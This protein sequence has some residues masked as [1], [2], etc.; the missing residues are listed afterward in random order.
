MTT[1]PPGPSRQ[2][3]VMRR[4][5]AA[6]LAA[7]QALYQADIGQVAPDT[8]ALEF[9]QHR[10]SEDFDGFTLGDIDQQLFIE[11]FRGAHAVR[12]D[13]DDMLM[14][15]IAEGWSV[16]RLDSMLRHILR[17]AAWELAYRPQVHAKV[18]VSE[19]VG[20][21]HDFFDEREAGM[22]NG[23]LNRLARELR[24]D[25]FQAD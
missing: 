12:E 4:R 11:V 21:A 14:A 16:E 22:A 7:V 3:K 5:R 20:L 6:R 10:L 1:S 24:P 15:V 8:V 23:M 2:D 9:L 13:L 19:Y 17:A 25:D 18:V